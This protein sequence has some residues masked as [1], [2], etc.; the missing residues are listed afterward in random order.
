MT[1]ELTDDQI[2]QIAER[3]L[4][5]IDARERQSMEPSRMTTVEVAAL[6]GCSA[7]TVRRNWQ[8]WGLRK[9]GNGPHGI[10]LFDTMSVQEHVNRINQ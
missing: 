7:H 8:R 3:V 10:A 1:I 9:L 4:E 2:D 5:L 6:K